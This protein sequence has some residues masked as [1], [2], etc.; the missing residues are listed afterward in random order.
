MTQLSIQHGARGEPRGYRV[1][2]KP[3]P[4]GRPRV[5]GVVLAPGRTS[6]TCH[7]PSCSTHARPRPTKQASNH[8]SAAMR[9]EAGRDDAEPLALMVPGEDVPP[10]PDRLELRVAREPLSAH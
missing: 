10:A 3:W 4:M 7:C 8:G 9:V 6:G 1:D 5:L 2:V